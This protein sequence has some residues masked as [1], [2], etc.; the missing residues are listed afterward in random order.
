MLRTSLFSLLLTLVLS[1]SQAAWGQFKP[2]SSTQPLPYA[3]GRLYMLVP[4]TGVRATHV[5]TQRLRAKGQEFLD[6]VNVIL[7]AAFVQQQLIASGDL[8]PTGL[9]PTDELLV[10]M[11]ILPDPNSGRVQWLPIRLDTLAQARQVTWP[12]VAGDCYTRLFNYKAAREAEVDWSR[13][14]L[15]LRPVLKQGNQYFTPK[16]QVLT[17]YFVLRNTRTWYPTSGDNATINC[18]AQ[19]FLPA[20][21]LKEQDAASAAS[22]P[23]QPAPRLREE[24]GTKL[25]LQKAEGQVYTFWSFPPASTAGVDGLLTAYGVGDLRFQPQVGLIS[26]RY[27]SYFGAII[28]AEDRFFDLISIELLSAK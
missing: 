24:L 18:L 28:N 23:G 17:E 19:P 26:G 4:T 6:L 7:P 22:P 27:S 1:S 3:E 8:G 20:T 12:A 25:L 11:T 14:R 2:A 5:R 9:Y 10:T 15:D 16:Q 21:Y 13:R